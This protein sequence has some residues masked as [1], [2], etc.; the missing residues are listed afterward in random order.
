MNKKEGAQMESTT[1][2][3]CELCGIFVRRDEEHRC[4]RQIELKEEIISC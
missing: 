1:G 3:E 2:K 4:S